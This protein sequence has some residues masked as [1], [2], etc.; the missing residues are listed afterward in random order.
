MTSRRSFLALAGRALI[1]KP[2]APWVPFRFDGSAWVPGDGSLFNPRED[3]HAQ[4]LAARPFVN[5][6]Y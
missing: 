3:I 1:R 4:W 2:P 6:R 5:L